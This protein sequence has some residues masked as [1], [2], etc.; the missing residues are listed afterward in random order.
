ML[1]KLLFNEKF[2][3]LS[4]LAKIIYSVLLDRYYL[5]LKNNWRDTDGQIYIYFP[6]VNLAETLNISTP[7][8]FKALK[9]LEKF[10]LIKKVKQ[11][12]G[13]P[14]KIK[15]YIISELIAPI[16]NKKQKNYDSMITYDINDFEK[17]I[18]K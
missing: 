4:L 9:D 5:S 3:G 2:D 12:F 14:D 18:N 10:E 8:A 15:V 1:P 11:G 13:K 6:I 16:D 17:L 7:T